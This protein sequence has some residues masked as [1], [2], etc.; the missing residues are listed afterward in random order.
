MHILLVEDNEGDILLISEALAEANTQHKLSIIKDGQAA[1][2]FLER[3]NKSYESVMPHLV[4]LDINL[5]C[6][7]GYEVLNHIKSSALL[8]HL[9]VIMLSTSS[10]KEDIL[11]SYRSYAN[12]YITKPVE[13]A[14]Y[15]AVIAGIVRFWTSNINLPLI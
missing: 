15:E 14:G 8:K 2:D 10:S 7:N 9:P 11:S 1:I 3:D 4:L 12:C 13:A 6:R 5:P